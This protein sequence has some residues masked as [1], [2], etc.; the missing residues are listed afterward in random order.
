MGDERAGVALGP[1]R[2]PATVPANR[3]TFSELWYRVADLRPRL[4]PSVQTYRQ[5]FRGQVYHVV[6]DPSNNEFFRLD[7]AAYYFVALLDG[8]RSV[9]AVWQIANQHLGDRAPTQGEA[10]NLLG[11]LYA[12]NLLLGDL[13]PD[14]EGM[15]ERYRRRVRRE[16]GGYFLN[17][18]FARVPL[19]DPDRFLD[20]WLPV[21]RWAYSWLGLVFWAVLLA[22]GGYFLVGRWNELADGAAGVL[23]PEN[24]LW[25]YVAFALVKTIHE[26]GHAFACKKFGRDTGT[27]GEV[28]VMGIMFLVFMPVPYV[29]ATAAS[30]FRSKWH[31]MAVGAAGMYVELAVAAIAAI[32][33]THTS[34]GGSASVRAVHAVAYNIMFVASISTLLF[35]GNPL[36]RYDG[37]YILSDALELPNLYQRARDYLYY[38][39]KRYLFGVPHPVSPA[40]TPGERIWLGFYAIASGIYRV[41]ISIAIFFYVADKLFFVGALMAILGIVGWLIMPLG[42]FAK[43]LLTS[44]ELARTRTRALLATAVGVAVLVS[45]IG[46]I[47]LPDRSRAYGVV[48]PRHLAVIYAQADGFVTDF[49]PSNTVVRPGG[50]PLIVATNGELLAARDELLAQLRLAQIHRRQAQEEDPG[51]AS[52]LDQTLQLLRRRLDFVQRQIDDL[53]LKAP[54][55]GL[56]VSPDIDHLRGAYLKRGAKVGLVASTD[57]LIIRV[58]ADQLLGPHIEPEIGP[59]G[60]VDIRL[61]GDPRVH[62][63]GV[64]ERILVAGQERLPSAALGYMVGGGVATDLHDREGTKP[65]QPFFEIV[66]KPDIPRSQMSTPGPG[67][68]T[69]PLPGA[70]VGQRV[71]VRFSMPSKPLAEQCW[72]SLRQLFQQ[73]FR[74]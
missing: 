71:V 25:L 3:P 15:F 40:R 65:A 41:F 4:R 74:V 24:L 22:G 21:V 17:L 48:E 13:P 9:A 20:A 34:A 28:H 45:I 16:V 47:P 61:R 32:V 62:W 66:V 51:K 68:S 50:P 1:P 58:A 35:N 57:D 44:A 26:F 10:I 37:Y 54:I 55:A 23:D 8:T 52:I 6:R 67:N 33:W 46:L 64:I 30:A 53:S 14:T 18:L 7:D 59:G 69:R 5:V 38:L 43:Y 60:P 42:R 11:Q 2:D 36:L 27:G 49:V 73:R 19:L 70:G 72:R 39:V 12:A 63:T 56:W 29:D 31:K